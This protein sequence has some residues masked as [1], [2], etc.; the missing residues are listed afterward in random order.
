MKEIHIYFTPEGTVE[1]LYNDLLA[2]LDLGQL[3]VQRA[4]NVEFNDNIQCWE[5]DVIGEG[6]VHSCKSRDE[7]IQWEIKYL[8]R[9]F[10]E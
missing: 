10:E 8:E 1:G 5:V 3:H 7:A 4:S 2:E 6:I 9:K